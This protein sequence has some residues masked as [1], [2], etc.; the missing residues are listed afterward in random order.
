MTRPRIEPE[1]ID[2]HADQAIARLPLELRQ[3][4]REAILRARAGQW[5]VLEVALWDSLVGR[6]LSVSRDVRLDWWGK[7]VGES[8][9]GLSDDAYRRFIG[10]RILARHS[11]GTPDYLL[12]VLTFAT[13]AYRVRLFLLP[14]M[15]ARFEYIVGDATSST[16][17][18]KVVALLRAAAPKTAI[19]QVVEAVLAPFAFAGDPDG[20]GFG[21]GRFGARI[22]A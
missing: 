3:P 1:R 20:L 16:E 13:G 21:A 2:D 14:F 15:T 4:N 6:Y 17:R 10:A 5:Q 9:E 22:D 8:R 11:D 19:I 7:L 12:R 18:G